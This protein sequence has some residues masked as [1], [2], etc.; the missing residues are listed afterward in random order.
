MTHYKT[1]DVVIIPFPFV[2]SALSKPRPTL[3]LSSKEELTTLAMITTASAW[4]LDDDH[5]IIDLNI[6]GLPVQSYIRMKIFTVDTESIKKK[7]GILSKNDKKA[8]KKI[9]TI[10][11]WDWMK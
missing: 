10:L 2:D 8:V 11:F 3:V 4:V 1:G 7:I 9:F 6:A 5:E